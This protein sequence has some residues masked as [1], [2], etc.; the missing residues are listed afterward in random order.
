MKP[1]L[2]IP[3]YEPDQQLLK[4]AAKLSHSGLPMVVIDDG[5]SP[6]CQDIFS[7]LEA[8]F[9][10]VLCRHPQNLGKGAAIKTGIRFA[11][12]HFPDA[13]GY[14]TADAD[15][16]HSAEDILRIAAELEK[17]PDRPILGTREFNDP[18]VPFKSRWGN[19]ITSFIFFLS[20]RR[21]CS[22]TQ[23]GLRGLPARFAADCLAIP[24][25]RYEYEMAMLLDMCGKT[26]FLQV[27]IATIYL[28]HNRASHFHPVKDSMLIYKNIFKYSFSSILSALVDLTAFTI[29]AG[30][31]LPSGS[32]GIL[33]ATVIARLVSGSI[34]FLIN[35]HWVFRSSRSGTLE[36]GRYLVLFCSQMLLS[37][38]LVSGLRSLPL[39]LPLVK[40]LVDTG[41]FFL[42]YRIQKRF[43]FIHRKCSVQP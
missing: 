19:R 11:Q 8:Q 21:R 18:Q 28:E 2:I 6:A 37:W 40:V 42:S 23:T 36:A 41:L 24:E 38:L 20:T 7:A 13:C 3:A 12:Y 29:L 34:N 16:Q 5:S 14:V 31:L 22:D 27:P 10:V 33:A 25:N 15:G 39:P 32:A 4:L 26:D 35:K 30:R 1:V 43:I 9:P 17:H